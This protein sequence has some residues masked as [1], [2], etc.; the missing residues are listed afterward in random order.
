MRGMIVHVCVCVGV[1]VHV[2]VC[3]CVRV[4]VGVGACGWVQIVEAVIGDFSSIMGAR[5]LQTLLSMSPIG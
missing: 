4:W 2:C 5:C 3:V 1:C